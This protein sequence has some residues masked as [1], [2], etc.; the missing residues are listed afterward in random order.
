MEAMPA[1]AELSPRER[2]SSPLP[3][4]GHSPTLSTCPQLDPSIST[5]SSVSSI[6]GRSAAS[7]GGQGVTAGRRRG[8][9]RPQATIFSESAKNRE[10][11]M[12]LGSIAHLQYYFARTGLLDGKGAQ[13]ARSRKTSGQQ[14]QGDEEVDALGADAAALSVKDAPAGS[15]PYADEAQ[16]DDGLVHSPTEQD[17]GDDDDA[18]PMMLPP[19]VSTY[20]HKPTYVPPPPDMLVLRRELREALDETNKLI[21]ERTAAATGNSG[22]ES[23]SGAP[24]V[25]P[26]TPLEPQGFEQAEGLQVLD[27]V[28]LA[29]RAAKNYYTA[30]ERPQVLYAINSERS[31][32]AQLHQVLELLKRLAA[33]NFAGGMRR[34]ERE[35]IQT[36]AENVGALLD[37][38]E[39]VERK[40][41][42]RMEGW[43]WRAGDWAG[44]ERERER[45][46]LKSFW[47]KGAPPAEELPEWPEEAE[48]R[49]LPNE[50]LSF[51]ATG[52]TL[53][54]LHNQLVK[55]SRRQFAFVKKYHTDVAKPYRR[56]ENI[57]FWAKAADLR[58]E[59][60]LG[61]VDV[62]GIASG[63]AD[64]ESWQKFD[65]AILAW[66]RGVREEITA[67][68][69][70]RRKA[71]LA[72]TPTLRIDADGEYG[73]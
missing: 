19:T 30:H 9:M 55:Q 23:P 43:T 21:E 48:G 44:R 38:E 31:M 56:A 11:V 47:P 2:S 33:R 63:T 65:A 52:T 18:E 35:G 32:R 15:P 5:A 6:S 26:P 37:A 61:L 12:S 70:E 54:L 53:V 69:A 4:D 60:K 34:Y 14:Q 45:L 13:M 68:W 42:E 40:E 3:W 46:F 59:M 22:R 64:Q 67:D 57:R 72:R 62:V 20:N 58:W 66:C 10:S 16:F 7:D 29:I 28:T 36:W 1:P 51:L 49:R 41:Q 17:F 71:S 73:V 27:I 39:A 50:F 8:Y 25:E 24:A